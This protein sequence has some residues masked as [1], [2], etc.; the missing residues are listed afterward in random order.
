MTRVI[1]VQSRTHSRI[2]FRYLNPVTGA[3]HHDLHILS[4]EAFNKEYKPIDPSLML[5]G[6]KDVNL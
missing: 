3:E 2:W 4:I 1:I 6:R 5:L